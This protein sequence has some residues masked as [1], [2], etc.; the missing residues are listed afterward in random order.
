MAS[1]EKLASMVVLE[2]KRRTV[3]LIT[4]SWAAVNVIA[5]KR[6]RGWFGAYFGT[7][8]NAR[9][10]PS[11]NSAH[12]PRSSL[13]QSNKKAR[14]PSHRAGECLTQV[15]FTNQR[16]SGD[17]LLTVQKERIQATKPLF[18]RSA[19]GDNHPNRMS[20]ITQSPSSNHESD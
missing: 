1:D 13:L 5:Q 9:Q 16:R 11:Q 6:Q 15:V 4:G 12:V 14:F 7:R 19:R 2:S 17:D 20:G 8:S 18:S 3:C 10:L